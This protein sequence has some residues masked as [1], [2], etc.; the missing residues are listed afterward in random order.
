MVR[1]TVD[2]T[3]EDRS[4]LVAPAFECHQRA[5]HCGAGSPDRYTQYRGE[6]RLFRIRYANC[7][8]DFCEYSDFEKRPVWS[9]ADQSLTVLNR[10]RIAFCQRLE[11]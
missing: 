5:E 7:V 11:M 10:R 3:E 6:Q 2:L 8:P 9:R 1:G 4:A